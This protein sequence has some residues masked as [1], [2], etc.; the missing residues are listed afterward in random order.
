[1]PVKAEWVKLKTHGEKSADWE[2]KP[3]GK[4]N[5]GLDLG[6]CNVKVTD[7]SVGAVPFSSSQ[8]PI[9]LLANGRLVPAW[10]LQENSAGQLPISPVEST[11][12]LE[13]LTLIP[14]G[15]A[16]LRITAF[17]VVSKT[18]SCGG[19]GVSQSKHAE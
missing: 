5:Y 11:S 15:A 19:A 3:Q 2:L 12:K 16:K 9:S 8:P 17:P 7:G 4:W 1:M 13:Q 6:D 14:Y 18:D 10:T